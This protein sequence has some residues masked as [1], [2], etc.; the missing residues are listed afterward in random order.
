VMSMSGVPATVVVADAATVAVVSDGGWSGSQCGERGASLEEAW[1]HGQAALAELGLTAQIHP[2]PTT[3]PGSWRCFL[4]RAG[5]PV[6]NKSG[7]GK[8]TSEAARVGALFEALELYLSFDTRRLTEHSSLLGA[9]QLATSPLAAEPAIALLAEGPDRPLACLPYQSLTDGTEHHVPL[10]VSL[11]EYL[12]DGNIAVRVAIGDDYDYTTLHRYSNSSGW[13]AGI[14]PVEAMVHAINEAIER[15]AASL[16]VIDQFLTG[17]PPPL[18][19]I[20]PATLPDQ[21][22]ELHEL[23]EARVG[24]RVWLIDITTELDVPSFW[25][26]TPAPH[27][28]QPA[29]L[30]GCGTSL[31]RRYAV[32]RALTELIQIH[33]AFTYEAHLM[34]EHLDNRSYPPLHRCYLADLAP[35]LP[36]ATLIPFADTP[37]PTTPQDHLDSLLQRLHDHELTAYTCRQHTS[38]HLAVLHVLTPG[39]ERFLTVTDG[40]VVLPGPRGRARLHHRQ[41]A[42]QASSTPCAH[43]RTSTR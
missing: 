34:P 27:P 33:S 21:L 30:R 14:S 3:D 12:E 13:A 23:A 11:P 42:H 16:L 4:Y 43:P 41:T 7:S 8:G 22:T 5:V 10:F 24:R 9:H 2:I 25:A 28:G 40:V 1:Q 36:N 15:D 29:R 38:D 20:D 19:I 32:E 39:L 17:Y 18:L 31:S 26:Y 35:H 6:P 37:T